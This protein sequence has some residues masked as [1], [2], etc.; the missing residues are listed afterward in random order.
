MEMASGHL[1]FLQTVCIE[2]ASTA[3]HPR[4]ALCLCALTSIIAIEAAEPTAFKPTI[5]RIYDDAETATRHVPLALAKV[6]PSFLT[7]SYFYARKVRPIYRTYP[8][9][10][11]DREP[12]G[13]MEMLKSVEP[14]ILW[15]DAGH[16]PKLET[17]ADWIR[18]GELVY[19]S[20]IFVTPL[21]E[22]GRFL[23]SEQLRR[24]EAPMDR[25]GKLPAFRYAVRVKGEV[26]QG[27]SSCADCHTRVLPDG[28]L[29][30]GEYHPQT[31]P[32]PETELRYSDEQA[33]AL[34]LFLH[35]LKAPSN[36][37]LPT[38]P[39]QI[40]QVE[41]GRKVFMDSENRCASCHDPQ[42]GFTNNKLTPVDG[43]TVPEDPPEK[44][45]IMSRSVHTDPT[46]GLKT[47]KGT[48]F[49]KVPTLLGLWHRGPFE[50]NGSVATLEDWFDERRLREDY[51][52]TGW[53][54]PPGTTTRA[55]KGH[56][57]GLDLSSEEK[58]V[59]IAFLKT[60]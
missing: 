47:R 32:P 8:V 60:L 37:N 39:V 44:E 31:I 41:R 18:A 3:M 11:P 50:H 57:F 9:Y 36:P 33:Y 45:H 38:T 13:Y 21:A 16:R 52:P 1:E 54:G 24:V 10:H 5:P 46:F 6:S 17:E 59:L 53:K 35:S 51:V 7:S 48:G 56:E 20:P 42:Q 34:A 4:N 58:R 23:S 14:E 22:L 27:Y 30:K 28:T 29:I 55:V 25:D 49:Y 2:I 19:D 43:F 12:A 40:E 15:D 26:E